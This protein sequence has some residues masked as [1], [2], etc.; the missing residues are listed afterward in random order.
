MDLLSA[1]RLRDALDYN[2]ETGAF[3]RKA[4]SNCNPRA[5]AGSTA[6]GWTTSGYRQIRVDGNRYFAHRLAWLYVYGQWPDGEVDHVNGERADNR[7]AN[8]R[9]ASRSQNMANAKIPK[10][11]TS[12]IKGVI[13]DK[14]NRKWMAYLQVDGRFKNLGRFET[15]EAAS[16]TR[17]AASRKAFGEYARTA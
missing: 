2:P 5:Q 9:L 16:A 1:Q 17:I 12:G 13:W 7:I 10:N 8:L 6:G 4:T 15:L 14:V 3:T 11:N